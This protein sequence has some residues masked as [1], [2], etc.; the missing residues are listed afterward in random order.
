M[1]WEKAAVETDKKPES[2]TSLGGGALVPK[3]HPRIVFRGALDTL[4]AE[5]LEAQAFFDGLPPGTGGA[6]EKAAY[7]R[8]ALGEVLA[9]V[10]DILAAEVGEK[11]LAVFT[12]FGLDP[13]EIR[14]QTHHTRETFGVERGLPNVAAGPLALRLNYLRARIRQG[15]TTAV[16]TGRED[17][18]AAMNRLSSALYWLYC[19]AVSERG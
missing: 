17:L 13:G 6:G 15:E 11:P 10:L 8:D 14:R 1:G 7:Y 16:A 18:T 9:V 12:L 5:L 2:V 3:N 19:K 4:V